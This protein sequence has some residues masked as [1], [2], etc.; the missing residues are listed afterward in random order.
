MTTRSEESALALLGGE[1]AVKA[2]PGDIFAWPIVTG[3][4]EAAVL[5]VI[6][7][8]AMSEGDITALFEED[9]TGYFG[10]E[11]AIGYCNGTASLR[12]G[13]FGCGVGV[14]DEIIAPSMTYWASVMPV[15]SLG[16]TVVFADVLPDT[17]CIDP[18]DIEHRITERTK[19]IVCVH[20]CGHPCDMD[21][22]MAIA[23]KHDLKVIEDVSHAHGGMYKGRMLG[24]IGD[25]ACFSTMSGKSLACGEAGALVT[26]DRTIFERA[27]AFGFYGRTGEG[28]SRYAA[29]TLDITLPELAKFRGVPL[30]GCKDR[31][32]QTCA[33]MGRVQL[34]H[35][36]ERIAEIQK[37]MNRFWDGL[38]GVPGILPHRPA[39]DSGSTMGG[40]YC[41]IGLYRPELLDNLHISR[42][43][44][45]V[46]AE[47]VTTW[48]GV[49]APLHLH[50]FFQDA[51][52]YGHGKPT[53][54]ANTSRDVRQGAGSLPVTEDI[55]SR[56]F[57]IPW[58]K[59]DRPGIID[60]YVAAFRKAAENHEDLLPE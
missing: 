6:R 34:R 47:G 17:V 25:V 32:N 9:L 24:S 49:N 59:H 13:M 2:D 19:A 53:M 22:I 4:D 26:S 23:Q 1:K 16:G 56:V 40:W 46:R 57:T 29:G 21:P 41:P 30:G 36:P 55:P 20:M 39:T 48:P 50:P 54:I 5:D 12:G 38:E 18:A 7:R 33:A 60:E 10:R 11:H 42:Y 31:M 43:C 35:Y 44:E 58:F 45:A 14:G 15:F 28:A 51:D 52:V 3:E 8:G 37:A 27:T